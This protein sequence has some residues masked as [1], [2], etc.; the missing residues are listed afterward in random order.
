MKFLSTLFF[1]F[2]FSSLF[3]QNFIDDRLAAIHTSR[4]RALDVPMH[5]TS[6][7][8]Y[9]SAVAIPFVFI[10]QGL[11]ET[12]SASLRRGMVAVASIGCA[13]IIT[14]AMKYSIRRRRPYANSPTSF[15]DLTR[16]NTINP[17]RSFP[18]GHSSVAFALATSTT[19]SLPKWYIAV[20]MFAWAGAVGYSRIHL[21]VHYPS[22]VLVGAAIGAGSAFL[23]HHL[24]RRFFRK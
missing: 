24:N 16:S 10:A 3:G 9:P 2:A 4:I 20:P 1:L 13:S 23:S 12:D 15:Q 7:S 6:T 8:L 21:G 19:L 5:M 11:Y 14:L 22:D 18:S 17:N